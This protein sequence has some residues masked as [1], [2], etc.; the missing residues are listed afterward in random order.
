ME[1]NKIY[2][3]DALNLIDEMDIKPNIIIMSP[4]DLAETNYKLTEYKEFIN[5]IYSKCFSKLDQNGILASITTDRKIDGQVYT[6]HIDIINAIGH[7]P[8]Q[9]K[10]WVK[11]NGVNLFILNYAHILF[12]RKSKKNTN[13][14]IKEFYP[15]VWNIELDKVDGYKN[16]DSFPSE[17]VRRIIL[18]FSNMGDVVLDPFIGTGKT[19]L[20]CKQNARNY[21]GFEIDENN[22]QIALKTSC[23]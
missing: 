23:L 22:F 9:Y 17:L 7:D 6:K 15:D 11:S 18:N 4:P 21:I 10:I 20:L 13:N 2:C 19:A 12:F 8:Y 14:K 3:G 1:V 5:T 16:K